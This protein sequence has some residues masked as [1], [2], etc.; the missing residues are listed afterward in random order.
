MYVLLVCCIVQ[1]GSCVETRCKAY[2]S[3]AV[4]RSG[5]LCTTSKIRFAANRTLHG[6]GPTVVGCFTA[7]VY[8]MTAGSLCMRYTLFCPVELTTYTRS[9]WLMVRVRVALIGLGLGL[10][11]VPYRLATTFSFFSCFFSILRRIG[12]NRAQAHHIS[13]FRIR[14]MCQF[15]PSL[16]LQQQNRLLFLLALGHVDPT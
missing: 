6:T 14:I 12:K 5:P 10:G 1:R 2:G 3:T 8:W 15:I 11:F 13:T 16:P 7:V 9:A 4:V